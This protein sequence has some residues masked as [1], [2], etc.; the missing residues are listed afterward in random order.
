MK[1]LLTAM[2][3]SAG[4]SVAYAQSSVSVYGLLD[5][6]YVGSNQQLTSTA[7]A[8]KTKTQ[9]SQFGQS[10]ETT[11]RLGFKGNEDLGGGASAFFTAEFQ[12]YPEDQNLSGSSN[13]GLLNRQTFVGVKQTGIGSTAVGR[14]YTPIFSAAA[15]TSTGQFNNVSGDVIFLG[16]SSG[17]AGTSTA[18]TI[19]GQENGIGF[20]NRASNSLTFQTDSYKGFTANVMYQLNNKNT[21]QTAASTGGE[22]NSNGYGISVDYTLDKL[23]V[24]A[25]RQSFTQFTTGTATAFSDVS[26]GTFVSAKDVQNYAGATYDFGIVKAYAQYLSRTITSTLDSSQFAKRSA[27][28]IG[29]RGNIRSNIDAWLSVGNGKF[30]QYGSTN[31][32][33][34]FTGYQV[35]SNY[36][37]SKRTNLYGIFGS[38]QSSGDQQTTA[39]AGSSKNMYAAGI[40]HTF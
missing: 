30:D 25:A 34:S 28:Q 39:G 2:L 21:T 3:L 18:T 23:L 14:Q 33:V 37:L 13:S 15:K 29:V 32:S 26:N 36:Y 40:R 38:T 24:N 11:S 35:G 27:Q 9:I 8:A 20:T 10:A 1:K 16:S 5:V 4:V 17:G 19:T 6:G 22:T 31:G 12:M 7:G